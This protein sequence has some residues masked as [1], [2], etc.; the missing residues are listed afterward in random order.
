MTPRIPASSM[1][2]VI[3]ALLAFSTTA[4]AQSHDATTHT[5]A[6]AWQQIASQERPHA[7]HEN[8]MAAIGDRLYLLGG[9]GD[10]PLDIY[11]LKTRRWS[12][13]SAPPLAISHAQV[14]VF[15]QRLYVVGGFLGDYPEEASLSHV[16]VYDPTQ[17][18]WSTGA[19]IPAARRRGAAGLVAH[20][21][22]LYLVGGNTRGHMSGYVSWL[23]AFDPRSGRW[24]VLPDAPRPRD[25]LQAAVID[26]RLYAAGGRRSAH[27]TGDTLAQTIAEVDVYDIAAGS[28]NTLPAPLPTPRAGAATV[29]RQGQL[30]LIGGESSRQVPA[31]AEV[32]AWDPAGARWTTLA[33][34]PRGR[35]GTQAAMID[36]D[37]YIAAGSGNRGG[38]PELDDLLML[39]G[40][41]E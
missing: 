2:W 9:R 4:A 6:T 38:G 41:E 18:R 28:W 39:P 22:V 24:T 33:A 21:G 26:G 20:D 19:E 40:A 1:A 25:H 5:S 29:A 31:H 36:G 10:R 11:D 14:A 23:D 34:L 30:V 3:S 27:E 15:D 12:Q 7:R 8:S 35:H 17:D 32:E 37:L 13:G 16:L